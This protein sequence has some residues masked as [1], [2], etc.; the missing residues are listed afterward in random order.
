MATVCLSTMPSNTPDRETDTESIS[1]LMIAC[2]HF[3]FTRINTPT[4]T[5]WSTRWLSQ[6]ICI[7]SQWDRKLKA[8][9]SLSVRMTSETY[10]TKR[11]VRCSFREDLA[12]AP[13]AARWR[14]LGSRA[15]LMQP[16]SASRSMA[17][18]LAS[19][20]IAQVTRPTITWWRVLR[21]GTSR[22]G[23]HVRC[24]NVRWL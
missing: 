4:L 17:K 7:K 22:S 12:S 23:R 3:P 24:S 5:T 18:R 20:T 2:Q 13:C 21:S 19:S 8:G 15:A 10:A 1:R 16:P 9:S 11:S 14:R 6:S